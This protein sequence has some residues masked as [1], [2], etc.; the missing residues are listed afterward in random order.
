[1][2]YPF[3]QLKK[4]NNLI[5]IDLQKINKIIAL[6][7]VMWIFIFTVLDVPLMIWAN[8]VTVALHFAYSKLLAHHQF[9]LFY[10]AVYL[11]TSIHIILAT[12]FM[13]WA[14]GF[15]YYLLLFPLLVFIVVTGTIKYTVIASSAGLYLWLYHYSQQTTDLLSG[16]MTEIFHFV[17]FIVFLFVLTF[18]SSLYHRTRVKIATQ[19][20]NLATHDTLTGLYNRRTMYEEL[21]KAYSGGQESYVLLLDID[22]FKKIND[23]YGHE[24]GDKVLVQTANSLHQKVKVSGYI[25]RWGGEEFLALIYRENEYEALAFSRKI[26]SEMSE[27]EAFTYDKS[28][29]NITITGGLAKLTN[30]A[31][32]EDAIKMADQAM[33][34]GKQ[35][36][37]N[38]VVCWQE[39]SEKNA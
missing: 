23:N 15:H 11:Q 28:T 26:I 22:D 7:H 21:E 1:M 12:N 27:E 16:Q 14:A 38:Q 31:S 8:I 6:Q 29:V 36:G 30:A 5:S 39:L 33:Y 20:E 17:N 37:K 32:I 34:L 25:S 13:G 35:S 3:K 24:C 9:Q 2:E 4:Y 19:L 10:F 18:I